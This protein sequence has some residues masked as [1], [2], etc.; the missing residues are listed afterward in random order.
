MIQ[1]LCHMLYGLVTWCYDGVYVMMIMM[2]LDSGYDDKYGS[3]RRMKKDYEVYM[4][5]KWWL[6]YG[7]V[8]HSVTYS[9]E[10]KYHKR[11]RWIS[12]A[13][14]RSQTMNQ[15]SLLTSMRGTWEP[16]QRRMVRKSLTSW[17]KWG[18]IRTFD[19]IP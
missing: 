5:N 3:R 11:E 12:V 10:K 15:L 16:I 4:F 18:E 17:P 7:R 6:C 8:S 14:F 1:E 9:I 19:K 13:A 2:M